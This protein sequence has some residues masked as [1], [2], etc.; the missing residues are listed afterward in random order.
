MDSIQ[1]YAFLTSCL[2]ILRNGDSKFDGIKAINEFLSLIT[3]K[4]VENRIRKK[5]KDNEE[6][7]DEKIRIGSDC[8]MTWLYDNYCQPE[9]LKDG[10]KASEL[11]DLLY[12]VGRVWT[13]K[14]KL[15]DNLNVLSEK[16]TRNDK[17][18]CIFVRFNQYTDKLTNI[19]NNITD[20]KNITSF[21]SSHAWDIQKLV[22]KIHTTIGNIDMSKLNY[23]AFGEA[24]EKMMADELG[25]SSKRYGQYFTRRDLIDLVIKELKI[26]ST[27]KCY[28]PACGTGGFLLSFAKAMK[29]NSDFV[30]NNVWGQEF[31]DEVHKTMCFNMLAFGIDG[32]LGHI[33]KG[34][35]IDK[36]Y[37]SKVAGTFDVVGAN[38]PFGMSLDCMID[39]YPIKVKNSVA[40]FL[41]HIYFSLKKGGRAGIVIDRGIL[42]NGSNKPNSWEKKLRK[43][44]L[45]NTSITKIIN[46]PTGIFKHTNFATSVIFFTKGEPT[47]S[48]KY[49]EG[50]FKNEDKGKG[51]KPLYLREEK[52]L[53]IADIKN[54]N[55][56]LKWDDY[57]GEAD[58][59][60]E[61][62]TD[63]INLIDYVKFTPKK[64]EIEK[65]NGKYPYY[66]SSIIK[67]NLTDE[68]T[69]DEECL[70]INKVNGSGKC[71]IY[72]NKGK[73]SASSAVIIFK[74]K[75]ESINIRFLYYY[76]NLHKKDI[77]KM[78]SGGDKK[79]LNLSS[80]E[81]IKVFYLPLKHQEEIVELLD[82]IYKGKKITIENAD[83]EEETII[84]KYYMADTIEYLKD[85]PIFNLLIQKNYD[86]F[87]EL[88][89][90]QENLKFLFGERELIKRKK[91]LEIKG[92]LNTGCAENNYVIKMNLGDI[93]EIK[94]GDRITKG[95]DEVDKNSKDA[96]PVYGGG[97]ITFYT[98]K[99]N[100]DG[101]TLV[102]SRFGV[103]PKC[104]RI[105]K[106]KIWLHDNGMS[107]HIKKNKEISFNYLKY[108]IL[109]NS[110]QIF[111]K[112]TTRNAQAR[113]ETNK[114]L[115]EFEVFVP[116]LKVQEEIVK[117]IEQTESETSHYAIYSKAIQKE[118]DNVSQIVKNLCSML[119][120]DL[121][122]IE[123][124][125]N[126]TD[127]NVQDNHNLKL[128]D[129]EKSTTPE[130]KVSRTKK[131]IEPES[132]SDLDNDLDINSKTLKT[133]KFI[134]STKIVK[135]ELREKKNKFTKLL[136]S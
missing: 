55:Y 18:D 28:D 5:K 21:D 69:N 91:L 96:I 131:Q 114:L 3:L 10:K 67:H 86:D 41:Q 133:T 59:N 106:G 20:S 54:K 16:K 89:D 126:N 39:D 136:K 88:M 52:I 13:V 19:T 46:L 78:Y 125:N 124:N 79:S 87:R 115:R 38:P 44:L 118:L 64:K 120:I 61:N 90:L 1:W 65:I 74:P 111:K 94:F 72:F 62:K 134:K 108:Y 30:K 77:E 105:L 60:Q 92:I 57:W 98:N 103:S 112:F 100:R 43:F 99:H 110:K 17:D 45:E 56:S 36:F 132:D 22:A 83:G 70:I 12:N 84:K 128:I 51:D 50:Y 14:Q 135:G 82:E 48:I 101:E 53:N 68:F 33:S 25:N 129:F 122:Q 42:N 40:L 104:V 109:N 34:N 49:I 95:K 81:K 97:D 113:M 29:K 73:F 107:V 7:N 71:K 80:F 102:I 85:Y 37:H 6:Y 119:D 23:D 75:N 47:K 31:L 11:Y 27:D 8:K 4:L 66:N 116:P 9:H 58:N 76:L 2:D 35:S 117:K 63:I 24:Y 123:D 93:C 130:K 26:K 32:C 127:V 15:D 121:K